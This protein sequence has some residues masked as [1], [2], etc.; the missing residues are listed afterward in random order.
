MQKEKKSWEKN[1]II[2]C[3]C[4][5]LKIC[6]THEIGYLEKKKGEW[7]EIIFERKNG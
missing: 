1:R 7:N 5:N 3:L 6:N 4:N 2:G